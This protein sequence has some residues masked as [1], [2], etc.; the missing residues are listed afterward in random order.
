[1]IAAVALLGVLVLPACATTTAGSGTPLGAGSGPTT[2]TTEPTE[3]EDT[4]SSEPTETEDTESSEPT[5]TEDTEGSE[6][7]AGVAVFAMG[8]TGVVSDEDGNPLAEI[9]VSDPTAADAAPDEFSDPPEN[10]AFLQVTTTIT[11]IG[12]E[13][14]S[15][16]PFDFLVRY[17]DGTRVEYGDGS[18]GIYGYDGILDFVDLNPD[19]TITGIVVFDV[20]P[21]V[22][23]GEIVYVDISSRVLGA[24]TLP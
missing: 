24:W 12:P 23:G 10:G 18:S 7:P 8:E 19:E 9:T 2:D 3:T 6:P 15:A 22:T 1:M 14:F 16:A 11:N 21:A 17:E 5:E 13:L 20:D 4:E